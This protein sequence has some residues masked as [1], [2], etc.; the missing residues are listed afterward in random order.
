[1]LGTRVRFSCRETKIDTEGRYVFLYCQIEN[2]SYIVANLYILPPFK[3][4]VLYK[5]VEFL[6]DKGDTP[7][8][9]VGDFNEVL[10]R[11]KDQFPPGRQTAKVSEGRLAQFMEELGLCF[12]FFFF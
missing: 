1:M 7:V 10:D 8:I 11:R 4:E 9:V 5:L 3:M 6:E 2:K 12:L